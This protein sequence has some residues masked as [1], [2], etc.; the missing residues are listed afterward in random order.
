MVSSNYDDFLQ[1]FKITREHVVMMGSMLW[2]YS[3]IS[4]PCKLSTQHNNH[5]EAQEA[6]SNQ[7]VHVVFVHSHEC[8][9]K[10]TQYGVLQIIANI[11]SGV[12]CTLKLGDVQSKY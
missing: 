7:E 3:K 11:F 12:I 9:G 4:N 8:L 1:V 5:K 10:F 6:S 2:E